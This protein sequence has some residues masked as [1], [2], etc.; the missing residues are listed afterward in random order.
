MLT[1]LT[2]LDYRMPWAGD[3]N[4]LIDRFDGRALLDYLPT[5][6]ASVIDS[7]LRPDRDEDGIGNELRFERWHDLADKIRLHGKAICLGGSKVYRLL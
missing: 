2:T 3:S 1:D 6:P 4:V 5:E 7:G